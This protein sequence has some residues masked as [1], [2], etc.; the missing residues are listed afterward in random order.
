[1]T[2]ARF[3][4]KDKVQDVGYRSFVMQK[5]LESPLKKGIAK[6]LPDDRVEVLLDGNKKDIERLVD[7]LKKEKPELAENPTMSEIDY[8]VEITVPEVMRASQSLVLEQFGKGIVVL[9]AM[10][11]R[12]AK[13]LKKVLKP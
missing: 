6:N 10:P 4:I 5:I 13:E 7:A 3:Y 11:E 1:M 8:K 2:K 9:D 12:I